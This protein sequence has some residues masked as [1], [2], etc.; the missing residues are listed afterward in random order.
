[1]QTKA[2]AV[3][4]PKLMKAEYVKSAVRAAPG[5]ASILSLIPEG[6]V[7]A[8]GVI[9]RVFMQRF[10]TVEHV[11]DL[12]KILKFMREEYVKE[13][14]KILLFTTAEFVSHLVGT[15]VKVLLLKAVGNALR[16]NQV[17]VI[18]LLLMKGRGVVREIIAEMLQNV[19][20]K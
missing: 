13:A 3:I 11:A 14:V 1:M 5:A 16:L 6:I 15:V 19:S 9:E 18:D 7:K 12:V 10:I 4:M 17:H 20:L 8:V 2:K